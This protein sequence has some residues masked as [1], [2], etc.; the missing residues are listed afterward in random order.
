MCWG[1][2]EEV[3]LYINDYEFIAWVLGVAAILDE[4][5]GG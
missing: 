4:H 3:S 1:R 5:E 2:R